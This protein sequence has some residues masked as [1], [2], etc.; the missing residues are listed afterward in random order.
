VV[1]FL[2]SE[3]TLYLGLKDSKAQGCITLHP[4]LRMQ[5]YEASTSLG[6]ASRGEKLATFG[7]RTALSWPLS[8]RLLDTSASP[9]LVIVGAPLFHVGL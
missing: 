6:V 4:Y 1:R 5:G 7:D 3:V 8:R 9:P 2:V